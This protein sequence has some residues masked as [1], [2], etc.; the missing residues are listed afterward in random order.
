MTETMFDCAAT[1]LIWLTVLALHFRVSALH[2]AIEAL[3]DLVIIQEP[4]EGEEGERVA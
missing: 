2:E 3:S 1:L 4:E